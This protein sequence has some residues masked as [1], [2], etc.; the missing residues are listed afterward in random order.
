MIL[1]RNSK[2]DLILLCET[3]L[4]KS[5]L[6]LVNIP[7][8]TLFTNYRCDRKGGRTGILVRKGIMAK[9]RKDLE[10]NLPKVIESTFIEITAKDGKRIVVGSVYRPPN[11][12]PLEFIDK[13]NLLIS[14][15]KNENKEAILGIDHNLDLLKARI[16]KHTQVFIDDLLD[17]NILPTI[18]RPTRIMQN[19]ATLIDNILRNYTDSLNQLFYLLTYPIICRA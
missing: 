10:E 11:S 8:Y 3:F 19:T 15:V 16:H 13:L 9:P 4:N 5:N 6:K 2:A 14:K 18:S 17:K 1:N 12:I 7:D